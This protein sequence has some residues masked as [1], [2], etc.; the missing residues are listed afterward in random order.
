MTAY[1]IE[2][3]HMFA[4]NTLNYNMPNYYFQINVLCYHRRRRRIFNNRSSCNPRSI[5]GFAAKARRETGSRLV[6][7]AMRANAA[8]SAAIVA[9][10]DSVAARTRIAA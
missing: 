5:L 3:Q 1:K 8:I 4:E 7:E 2:V 9:V 10:K 6:T